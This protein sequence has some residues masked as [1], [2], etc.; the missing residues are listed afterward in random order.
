MTIFQPIKVGVFGSCVTR[1]NFNSIFNPGYKDVFEC[2]QL[3]D[4]VS[5]VSLMSPAIKFESDDLD[6][7]EPRI[8]NNL[9][10]EFNRS[11]LNELQNDPPQYLIIDFWPDLTFGFA[12]L[13]HNAIITHNAWSTTKT[14]FFKSKNA[15]WL[16]ADIEHDEFFRKWKQAADAFMEFVS[17]K[18]PST[19]IIV[20]S[21]RNVPTWKDNTGREHSFGP[22][23]TSMN[24]HW[25]MMDRYIIDNYGVQ[26]ISIMSPDIHSFES[27][28]WG[29]F[30][31]HYTYDYHSRFLNRLTRIVLMDL[32][33]SSAQYPNRDIQY[34]LRSKV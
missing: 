29:S 17:N 7:L 13:G 19:K 1:D 24:K 16:R 21:A 28:A 2:N 23:P 15:R 14:K 3:A 8:K 22:W 30:P 33:T 32:Q 31:V 18:L 4:H 25:E 10:R 11:F 5:L 20:H 34:S 12:T 9:I 27:H 6:G 26:S